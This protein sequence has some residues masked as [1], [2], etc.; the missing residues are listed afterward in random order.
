MTI[1]EG[2]KVKK[3]FSAGVPSI[4]KKRKMFLSVVRCRGTIHFFPLSR[5]KRTSSSMI[6]RR[7]HLRCCHQR[8]RKMID[9]V[10][11]IRSTARLG[12]EEEIRDGWN[13]KEN[14]KKNRLELK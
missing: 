9:K 6:G 10:V 5:V 8:Q 2:K 4:D 7:N 1:S 13:K 12:R 11:Q 14:E 3:H